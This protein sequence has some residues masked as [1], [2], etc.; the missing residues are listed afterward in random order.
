MTLQHLLQLGDPNY[1]IKQTLDCPKCQSILKEIPEN[2]TCDEANIPETWCSCIPYKK[3]STESDDVKMIAKMIVQEINNYYVH[4]NITSICSDLVLN[5]ITDA[6]LRLN[7]DMLPNDNIKTYTINFS[8][9]PKTEPK[10]E[11]SATADYNVKNKSIHLNVEDISR[12]SLYENTAKCTDDKQA[13]KYCICKDALKSKS[14]KK[15]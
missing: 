7:D 15:S 1:E 8:T 13:K 10:T 5:E 11:F 12:Q 14:T 9:L 3:E 4:K 2:R 6:K